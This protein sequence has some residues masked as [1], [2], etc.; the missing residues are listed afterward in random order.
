[1]TLAAPL[2]SYY[3]SISLLVVVCI[4]CTDSEVCRAL[5]IGFYSNHKLVAALL[6]FVTLALACARVG[7]HTSTT[8]AHGGTQDLLRGRAA[9][10]RRLPR[11]ASNG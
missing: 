6:L 5:S 10:Q 4:A 2:P 7:A 9:A 11:L 1:M 8:A 3:P